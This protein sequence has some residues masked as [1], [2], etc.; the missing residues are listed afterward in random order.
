MKKVLLML[1]AFFMSVQFIS[2]QEITSYL[3]RR[4]A[5]E[6]VD[7]YIKREVNYWSK[8]AES[9]MKKGNLTYWALLV[10]VAGDQMDVEPNILIVN[11]LKDVDKPI[12]WE[13][14]KKMFP[15]VKMENIETSNI[16]TTTGKVYLEGL[17]NHIQAPNVIPDKD[18]KYVR[19]TFHNMFDISW[20][21]TFEEEKI[22]PYFQTAMNAGKTTV[23]GWGNSII[24]APRSAGFPYRTE[25]HDLFSNLKDALSLN[26]LSGGMEFPLGYFTEWQKNI[27]E[28]RDIS[29]YKIVKSIQAPK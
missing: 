21:L 26:N 25:S 15:T 2:A 7:E 20:H 28:P 19:I 6:N 4:V 13:D 11:T 23:K 9:E 24:L 18:F 8:F 17:G 1:C 14:I 12:V 27:I 16:S 5:P 29:V 22:K 3:Y 10:R